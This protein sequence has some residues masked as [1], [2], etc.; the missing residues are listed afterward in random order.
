MPPYAIGEPT[1][2]IVSGHSTPG[3]LEKFDAPS[4]CKDHTNHDHEVFFDKGDEEARKAR[5][6][7]WGQERILDRERGELAAA[8]VGQAEVPGRHAGSRPRP[9]QDRRPGPSNRQASAEHR[10]TGRRS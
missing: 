2:Y 3:R 5:R 10:R 4:E 8:I 7:L 1:S 6:A 9:R